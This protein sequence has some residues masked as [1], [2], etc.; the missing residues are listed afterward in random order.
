MYPSSSVVLLGGNSVRSVVA[1]AVVGVAGYGAYKAGES[2]FKDKKETPD[3]KENPE[4]KEPPEKK[5][6]NKFKS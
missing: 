5:K 1:G 2:F 6:N 4:K 3:K